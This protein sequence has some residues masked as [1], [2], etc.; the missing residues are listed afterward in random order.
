[1]IQNYLSNR[2]QY[3]KL[4]TAL[5]TWQ[6]IYKG[7]PQ[8]SILGP[9]LFNIFINDIFYFISDSCLYNYADDNTLS[10]SGYDLDKIINTLEKDSLNLIDW[11]TSNQM[12]VNPDKFQAIATG[13]NTQ[14]KNISF[15]L[16]GNIIKTEDEV[17]LLGVTIDYELKFNSH[18]TN[19]CRKASRQ[20]N[21][22]K[23]MGKYL[24]RLGKLTIYHSFILSNF[25]YC[26]V[27]W[28]FCSEANTKKMEKIQERALK[29]IYNENHSTYEELLAKSKLPSLKIRRIRT[30]AIETFKIINK[31]TPQYLHDLV[32]LENNKYNLRYSNTA[33]IPTVKTT[34]YGLN[35]FRYCAS[36]TWNEL[37][38]HFRKE[39]SFN[40][41]KSLI[42][43]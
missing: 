17:K 4:G 1:M 36:E 15:N 31:E 3:V 35:S 22:L 9:V 33:H 38:D 7:V 23:R 40:Q 16:N 11:F 34:R 20:L 32:T 6:D 39:T 19:I 25:N 18:I 24:N 41:F 28:H 37:P 5:S 30:I 12:K 13:K 27:I 42:N 43:S 21:V 14:F 8:G 29:F 26:P 10:Y 2:K